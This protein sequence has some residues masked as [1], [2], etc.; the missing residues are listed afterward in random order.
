MTPE[1]CWNVLSKYHSISI[2]L[3]YTLLMKKKIKRFSVRD[4]VHVL[5]LIGAPV[6]CGKDSYAKDTKKRINHRLQGKHLTKK[7]GVCGTQPT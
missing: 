1:K 7:Q 2:S 6:T 3:S 5:E 4:M